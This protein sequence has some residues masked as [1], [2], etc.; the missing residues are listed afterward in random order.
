[1]LIAD[2]H[3]ESAINRH[4]A[5]GRALN[6]PQSTITIHNPQSTFESAIRNSQ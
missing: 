4:F 2:W 6:N 5:F 1:L 3:T